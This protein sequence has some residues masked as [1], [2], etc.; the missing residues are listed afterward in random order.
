M[1]KCFNLTGSKAA[2]MW[3]LDLVSRGSA[4]AGAFQARYYITLS[5]VNITNSLRGIALFLQ[6]FQ[7]QVAMTQLK[8]RPPVLWSGWVSKGRKQFSA[9]A[10]LYYC[11]K[12]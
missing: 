2:L 4:A 10:H 9:C 1:I 8:L 3:S 6:H 11:F 5:C 7:S 12:M